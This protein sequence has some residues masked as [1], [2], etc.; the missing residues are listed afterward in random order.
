MKLSHAIAWLAVIVAVVLAILLRIFV[1]P[2]NWLLVVIVSLACLPIGY[3]LGGSD[4]S[5]SEPPS[6][7]RKVTGETT[8]H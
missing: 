3:L 8:G 6:E 7:D 2:S 1:E 4:D 5:A